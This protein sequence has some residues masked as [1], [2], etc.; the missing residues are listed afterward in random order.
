[1][2]STDHEHVS[3]LSGAIVVPDT[4]VFV[5]NPNVLDYL[6]TKGV[7]VKIPFT[8]MQELDGLRNRGDVSYEAREAL[9][10]IEKYEP[11]N[12]AQ[13][14]IVM[15]PKFS[16]GTSLDRNNPDHRIIA[17][18]YKFMT[19]RNSAPV[20][21][22][23][24]DRPV[25]IIASKM[26]IKVSDYQYKT[27]DNHTRGLREFDLSGYQYPDEV[28]YSLLGD[29]VLCNEV[30]LLHY[31]NVSV[32]AR[33]SG[34]TIHFIPQQLNA[35]GVSPYTLNGD[36]Y[37]WSQH[38]ALGILLNPSISLVFLQGGAGTGKTLLAIASAIHQRRKYHKIVISRPMI[39]MEKDRMG[40]LPGSMEEKM[41]PWLKPITTSMSFLKKI[42]QENDSL[43]SRLENDGKIEI[44]PL[45]Y[46]KGTTIPRSILI[47]DEA[48][49]LT[50]YAMKAIITRAGER[51]KIIFTGDL[52]QIDPS[53]RISRRSSGLAYA[54]SKLIGN[55]LVGVVNFKDTVRSP[56]AALAEEV[57]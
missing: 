12:G 54:M 41:N 46:V 2:N 14:D 44:L 3:L 19:S 5:N 37:N 6:K 50:P 11:K 22:F 18:A 13:V 38:A 31:D 40:F 34:D 28:V 56:L 48:Q 39:P 33:K 17:T 26:G 42:S 36:E 24:Q 20:I 16:K 9:R 32:M 10:S 55:P 49:D 51:T 35:L 15:R 43:I 7:K 1:M 23:S 8:V 25:R 29:D 52:G 45:D 30:V 4:N 27:V 47:V 53:R 57:L 21:L